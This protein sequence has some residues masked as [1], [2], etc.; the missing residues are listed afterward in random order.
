[1]RSIVNKYKSSLL[2]KA[3]LLMFCC[4]TAQQVTATAHSTI[5]TQ[6]Q[7]SPISGI[8]KDDMGEPLIGAVV[9]I[10]GTT[11]GTITLADGSFNLEAP[12]NGT[13]LISYV[14][15]DDIEMPIA[16][17][18]FFNIQL[19]EGVQLQDV[20]VVALGVKR[21]EKALGYAV[22]N[23]AGD[24]LQTVKGVDI[25]STLTGKV[26]GLNVKN[27]T[28]FNGEVALQLRGETPLLVINGVPYGNMT[29]RDI[30]SDE[31]ESITTLK[32]ATAAAL[33][34]SR[35]SA[36]A[37]MVTTKGG[38][39]QG[40]VVD[41]NSNTMIT[42]GHIAIPETQKSYGRGI[43]G[44]L[45]DD[46]VWGPKLDIGQTAMQWNPKTKRMEEM[47]LVSSGANNLKNFLSTGVVTN[48]SL[49]VTQTTDKG[50]FRS[51]FNYVHNKGQFPNQKL[52][53]FNAA[54]SGQMKVSDKFVLDG[55]MGFSRTTAPQTWGS[56]YGTQGYIYQLVMWTG[57]D[58]DIRDYRDYWVTPNEEQNWLYK[59]WYDNPYLIAY[60]K[61]CSIEKNKFNASFNANYSILSN[62]KATLRVG[63]D[64]YKDEDEV[65]N[66]AGINSTR[67]PN[68]Q[69]LGDG[70]GWEFSGK[71]MYGMNQNWGQSLNTDIMLNYNET[72]GD[73]NID[74][75]GGGSIFYMQQR[76][77]GAHTLN[78][79]EV[80]GWYSLANAIP[81]T[82]AGM[83]SIANNYG[84]YKRQVNSFYGKLT[85]GWRNAVFVDITGRNDWSSTQ[86]KNQRSYFYPSVAASVVASEFFKKPEW[87]SLWKIRGSWTITKTPLGIYDSNLAYLTDTAWGETSAT[88][89]G[90][91]LGTNLAPS[92]SRTWE[93]GTAAYLF[94]RRLMID[95]AY[96]DKLFYDRQITQNIAN[97]SG[98][99]STLINTKET[100]ARRGFEI[101]LSGSPVKT[102]NW[103]WNTTVNMSQARRYYVDI[104]EE[105][106]M[107]NEWVQPGKRVD[108][109]AETEKILRDSEGNMIHGSNGRVMLDDYKRLYGYKD[110][111]LIMGFIN[112][113][114]YKNWTFMVNLDGRF[115]GLMD[116][117]IYG[118]MFDTGTAPETD[119]IHRY[120]EVVNGIKYIG[121][122]VKVISGEIKY[123]TQGNILSDTRQFAPNDIETSY[124]SYI[125]HLGNSWENR[126]RS[127]TFFKLREVAVTYQ[128]PAKVNQKLGISNASVSVTGQNLFLWTKDFKYSDPDVGTENL[129]A[130]AQ[131]MV[132]F[133]IKF[134]F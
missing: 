98:Y 72:F 32:G 73:F 45:G 63:Y 128:V 17:K 106:S 87:L 54:V 91:L 116:N 110:P 102:K 104:D 1:M 30:S 21:E 66:P 85:V 42:A 8:V 6:Q 109:Y 22:Q 88:L 84:H 60:E 133:N 94:G 19:R 90:N 92:A 38:Q 123:D 34:G 59:S 4:S 76:E 29:L 9:M 120:N 27:S 20:V 7:N 11:N 28:E 2:M 12:S 100:I 10:K 99:S 33:Y 5:N 24:A 49:S 46:Y 125:K 97:S 35:G 80:P 113:V 70:P 95:V 16:G 53:L 75:L 74:A 25:A 131:R 58:Y 47:P 26:A 3:V 134:G 77:Q 129:N 69:R 93:F 44:Q 127:A 122:G 111:N 67:G 39:K 62:L 82:T 41:I 48:N 81:S 51:S 119:N 96:F 115:G 61:L 79:L 132:G 89:P 57:P 37:I 101:T 14:G 124:E 103:E 121:Q 114:T 71:G 105:Y 126:I 130:P 83:N 13:L 55:Q 118:K 64:Y 43:G 56:G 31:I 68:P 50:F 78:G 52:D 117:Q 18:T 36:G 112:T 108:Y 86:P 65:R 107:K 23:V 15:Y 40:L